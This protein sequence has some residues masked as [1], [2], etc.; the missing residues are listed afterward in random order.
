MVKTN[1]DEILVGR[2]K[3]GDEAA[4]IYMLT[5]IQHM[6][7]SRA[8]YHQRWDRLRRPM[9]AIPDPR[10]PVHEDISQAAQ[11]LVA[12]ADRLLR[13]PDQRHWARKTYERVVQLFPEN[14]W[15]HIARMRLLTMRNRSKTTKGVLP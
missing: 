6:V 10:M 5:E 13:A 14:N 9:A 15:A 3:R 8:Q 7:N 11:T 12:S 4:Q 1:D 2:F